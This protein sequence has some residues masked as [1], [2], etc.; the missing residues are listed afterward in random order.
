[1]EVLAKNIPPIIADQINSN[2]FLSWLFF[3][4]R[5]KMRSHSSDKNQKAQVVR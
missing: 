1:M 3:R 5:L 2:D 4:A